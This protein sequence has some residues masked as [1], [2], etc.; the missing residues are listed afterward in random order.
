MIKF[1]KRSVTNNIVV[2]YT[3]TGD[4]VLKLRDLRHTAKQNGEIEIKANFVI[5]LEGEIE[6]ARGEESVSGID[7]ESIV[8]LVVGDKSNTEQLESLNSLVEQLKL[9]YLGVTVC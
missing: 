3:N 2:Q 4:E 1:K 9:K 7:N 8:I 6:E 5:T